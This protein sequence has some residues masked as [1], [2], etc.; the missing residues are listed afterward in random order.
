MIPDWRAVAE[1]YEQMFDALN[2]YDQSMQMAQAARMGALDY[3]WD[4]VVGQFWQPLLA[5]V[6]ADIERSRNGNL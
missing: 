6:E 2:D 1:A 5:S 4:V 3:A